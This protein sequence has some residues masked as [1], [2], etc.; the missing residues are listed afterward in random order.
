MK[1]KLWLGVS[2]CAVATLGLVGCASDGLKVTGQNPEQPTWNGNQS[3]TAIAVGRVGPSEYIVVTYNDDTAS[4]KIQYTPTTRKVLPGATLMGWSYSEDGG[5]NWKYGGRVTPNAEWPVLWGDPAITASGRD[6]R[7]VFMSNLAVPAKLMPADGISGSLVSGIGGACIAR[8]TDGGRTF[9]LYQCVHKNFEFYDGG[10]MASS[11]RG[12]IYVAYISVDGDRYDV[13]HTASETGTFQM[14]PNPFP[15]CRMATH[16]RIRVGYPPISLGGPDPSLYIAGQIESC[17]KGVLDVVETGAFG[18]IIINRYHNGAWGKPRVI[19]Y[20]SQVNPDIVLFDRTL[21][22]GPQFTFDVGTAGE[23]GNDHIRMLYTRRDGAS[24]RLFVEG[25]F[26]KDD[27]SAPCGY[28]PEW[29]STPGYYSYQGDQFSPNI[30]AFPGF[31]TI[32][33]AWMVTFASRDHDPAGNTVK[34][35]RGVPMVLS[36]G[37]RILISFNLTNPRLVCPDSQPGRGYWGDYDDLQFVGFAQG[38]V[39]AQFLR[40]FSDSS[41]G[42]IKRWAFTSEHLH[43]NA[44]RFP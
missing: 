37:A 15:G 7:Y 40:A 26:C 18:Q 36:G 31:L 5:S 43:V 1:T 39:N 38:S 25:T 30:R 33:S 27:L 19:S 2:V 14:L 20:P 11:T 41:A 28:A 6:P 22:T 17:D 21:R 35:R 23:K 13:W 9:G 4:N 3:E 44:V 10:T 29:G 12:D 16:P 24:G 34:I 8:S 32:P 42:C